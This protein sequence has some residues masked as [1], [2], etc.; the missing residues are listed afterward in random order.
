MENKSRNFIKKCRRLI[1]LT[2]AMAVVFVECFSHIGVIKVKAA[3]GT[4]PTQSN[5]YEFWDDAGTH[6]VV[7][8]NTTPTFLMR[9]KQGTYTLEAPI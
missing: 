9:R 6:Y 8:Q 7:N 4:I 2:I 5:N 1:C 3:T